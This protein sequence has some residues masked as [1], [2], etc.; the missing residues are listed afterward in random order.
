VTI[1]QPE[2]VAVLMCAALAQG[3]AAADPMGVEYFEKQVRP[4]LVERCYECHSAQKKIKGGLR[5]DHRDGWVR[6]G[7]N[8]AAIVPGDAQRSLLIK[9]IEY[10]DEDLQMP[11]KG[12]LPA[13]QIAVL[14]RWVEMGAP[15]PRQMKEPAGAAG[16]GA[17]AAMSPADHFAYKP[18]G[19]PS[20]PTVRD[21]SWPRGEVDRFI[22]SKLEASGL[23]PAPDADRATLL[24]RVRYDLTG[25]PPTVAELE[26][27]ESD[28]RP[29][30]EALMAV[31]DRLLATPQYG[32]RWGRHWLDVARFAESSGGGRSLAF[33]EAWRY[34]D[35]VIESF[36]A[37]VPIDRFITEQIAGDL[38]TGGTTE[39]RQRQTIATGYLALGPHNYEEQDKVQLEFDVIDE[40]LETIGKG[41][42]GMTL[43]C[44]RCHDH[45]FDPISTRDYYALAGIMRSTRMLAHSNVSR[46]V[47]QPLPMSPEEEQRLADHEKQVAALKQRIEQAKQATAQAAP[48]ASQAAPGVVAAAD[49]PGIIVDDAQARQIGTWSHSTHVKRY[50]GQGYLTDKG[51]PK[52]GV[53][54]TFQPEFKHA[55]VYEVRLAYVP[56]AARAASV[57]YEL[58]TADG[59]V[60]GKVDMSVEP[61]IDGRFVSLG[62][63]RFDTT[64]QWFVMISSEGTNGYVCVDAVQFLP[65]DDGTDA[66]STPASSG[67]AA[68]PVAGDSRPSAPAK[69]TAELRAMEKQ[70]KDMEKNK[71]YR[72]MS[73]GVAEAESKEDC[74]IR[75]RGVVNN[76]GESVPRGF[77]PVAT[78]SKAP[79][80]PADQ[81]GRLQLAQWLTDPSHPLTSRVYVNRVWHHLFGA[82]LVRT[83][84]NFGVTG[85]APAHPE[86]L[87]HL[88]RR[89]MAEGWSTRKLVRSIVLSRTYR[90]STAADPRAVAADPD[91]R[92]LSHANR[93][94][95][96]AEAIRDSILA[97]SGKLDLSVGGSTINDPSVLTIKGDM[98]T[99]YDFVFTDFRRGVYTPA[100]RNRTLELYEAFDFADPNSV[101]GKRNIST[102][103]PQALYM[104]NS[105]FVMQ[106]A[107]FAAEAALARADRTDAQR[108][109][110]AF[111][112]A[113]ARPPT[114][115]ERAIAAAA[116]QS[117]GDRTEAW[118][119][120]HQA[121]IGCIDFRYLH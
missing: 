64:N 53:T 100:F 52:T 108:I 26:A 60:E 5:L 93:R 69:T 62:R 111:R 41:L 46:W 50:I 80:I 15:D 3:A 65:A 103:A 82:G 118:A 13:G 102:V 36:N 92:L 75:I 18:I 45:K 23:K 96:D 42:M 76:L 49:L 4:L 106:Q 28:A 56:G 55:G 47:E 39:Q 72:P 32:E 98:P 115:S 110:A 117:S 88:A 66:A 17:A 10:H 70:L 105:P 48:A 11:P 7:D 20:V 16:A 59:E 71:P 81:S 109:D 85:E 89:F 24:R 78:L 73:M 84:D 113:L 33:K 35:Y 107:R 77:L 83:T 9:A 51:A 43:G 68:A 74:C 44:A 101:V 112:A 94:R 87:D 21:G 86:L 2:F 90:Q 119:R 27:F 40:Q 37:D 12:K 99:E 104:L 14:R 1:H 121:L 67:S 58:L 95:L 6:G 22:L 38:M 91:N 57:P 79:A 30:D 116:L 97:L 29:L 54:L 114:D 120:F 61:P 34:R 8:G 31:V 25:L 19:S 63:H